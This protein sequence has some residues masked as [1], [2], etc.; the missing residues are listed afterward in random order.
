MVVLMETPIRLAFRRASPFLVLAALLLA[1]AAWGAAREPI[2]AKYKKWL[3]QDAAYI[4]TN[5]EK[6]S[7]QDLTSDADRDRFIEHFWEVR[8]PTPGS[9][10]NSY[11]T[12]HYRRI[13][14]AN[15]FFGHTSHTEGWRTDMGR[16]YITL[17][18]PQQRQKL[19]GLQKITPME[20]WFYSNGN[21]ALPP[22][23]YV[24]FYQ[25]D[26][27]DE[28]RLYHPYSDGPEKLITAAAGPSRQDALSILAQDAGKD[29]ARETLSLIP[30]EPVDF[31][32]GTTSL[33][34]DVMLGAITDLANNPVSKEELANRRR[35]LED[36]THQVVLGEEFLDVI[37]V[38]LRNPT[39]NTNLHYLLRLKKPDDFTVGQSVKTGYYYS[40]LVSA[41]VH[42]PDGKVIFSDDKKIS[43]T[44]SAG[45][46]DDVKGKVFGYEGVLPLPPGKYK[47][48][49]EL[50]NLL[51]QVAFH[52]DVEITIPPVPSSG[53][54]VSTIVPF[55]TAR[56]SG[57][58][59][60]DNQPF[61]GAGVSFVPRAGGELQLVQGELLK[62]FYQ[63][64]APSLA[65][66]GNSDKKIDVEYV[67]G[68]LGAQD[69]KTITDQ[70]PLNQLDGGGSVINGKQILTADLDPGN[71][72]LVM[73]LHDPQSQAKV[74]GSLS[75]SINA[76]TLAAPAWDISDESVSPAEARWQRA[77]CYLAV[78]DKA[79]A[80]NWLRAAFDEDRLNERY[81]D[82]L[83]E[84]YFERQ[85]YGKATELYSQGGLSDS[86]DEQTIVRLAESFSK[87]GNLPKAVAVME[88]GATLNPK[89]ASLQLGL[90]AYYRRTGN[91]DKA[92]AA[93][94]RGKQL[95]SASPAS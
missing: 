12:E 26:V 46:L 82:K 30:D 93:E 45:D 14:Y 84:L 39:G 10:D 8:N 60:R 38:P 42:G 58:R 4:I 80:L 3:Q 66:A 75:F 79:Q 25:R 94:Q 52:R 65:N 77:L 83:I 56:T 88:S 15:Q 44:L 76:S 28:F 40:I 54:Q 36:V 16:V 27:M 70:I 64:W 74:F 68:R 50:S 5:E 49:F 71:Y 53:L 17:G 63:V 89:S 11:R 43:K 95:M 61:T 41:K 85:D 29:V 90:A 47:I 18:E 59:P 20:I 1:A 73:T 23:F 78:N 32:S 7:F 69:S 34:S 48:E 81:R 57:Q 62:F 22:F 31:S 6:K 21:P 37:T 87:L 19:L 2:P 33:A 92:A 86:T 35:L 13:E 91:P 55:L 9:P 67:Y 72:R 24:I 51:S